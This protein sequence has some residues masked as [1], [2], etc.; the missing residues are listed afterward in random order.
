MS[1]LSVDFS[2]PGAHLLAAQWLVFQPDESG[3]IDV[4]TE[5]AASWSTHPRVVEVQSLSSCG[6]S[7]NED[8]SIRNL[9]AAGLP[10]SANPALSNVRSVQISEVS[11]IAFCAG[12]HHAGGTWTFINTPVM[13]AVDPVSGLAIGTIPMSEDDVD[14]VAV[15]FNGDSFVRSLQYQ[16]SP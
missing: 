15:L 10:T 16:T 12:V 11:P 4:E 8:E 5:I 13:P 3:S 6:T 2:G 14:L 1:T 7:L 9:Q